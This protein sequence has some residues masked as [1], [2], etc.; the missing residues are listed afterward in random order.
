MKAESLSLLIRRG[1]FVL[2]GISDVEKAYLGSLH[3]DPTTGK[4]R[5]GGEG[6]APRGYVPASGMVHEAGK[7][8]RQI[9]EE[10]H[11]KMAPEASPSPASQGVTPPKTSPVQ[12]TAKMSPPVTSGGSSSPYDVISSAPTTPQ[13][14]QREPSLQPG[15]TFTMESMAHPQVRSSG[16]KPPP[17]PQASKPMAAGGGMSPMAAGGGGK[18]PPLPTDIGMAQTIREPAQLKV[19]AKAIEGQQEVAAPIHG[20]D[21]MYSSSPD[22]HHQAAKH[23]ILQMHH[24]QNGDYD[25]AKVHQAQAK[26][27]V[28]AGANPQLEHFRAAAQVTEGERTAGPRAMQGMREARVAKMRKGNDDE[29]EILT[30]GKGDDR[31]DSDFDPKQLKEGMK[32]EAEHTPCKR[33]R[34]EISK[35]HLTEDKKYYIKLKK[36]EKS[37]LT[38]TDLFKAST[39]MIK[40]PGTSVAPRPFVSTS[41]A[42]Q[43]SSAASHPR[44][45][46]PHHGAI[47]V[48]FSEV[49]PTPQL[50]APKPSQ[51]GAASSSAGH[52]ASS[53]PPP[54]ASSSQPSSSTGTGSSA[55]VEGTASKPR[56]MSA[57]DHAMKYHVDMASK[58]SGDGKYVE[59]NKHQRAANAHEA[60]ISGDGESVPAHALS[61][62]LGMRFTDEGGTPIE[63]PTK[64]EKPGKAPKGPTEAPSRGSAFMEGMGYGGAAGSDVGIPGG[65]MAPVRAAVGLLGSKLDLASWQSARQGT[66][67]RGPMQ[68]GPY[69]NRSIP[70]MLDLHKS[71]GIKLYINL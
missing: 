56:P 3:N 39:A 4:L 49:K 8:P 54:S 51:S 66:Q 11:V 67:L 57:H 14:H 15:H 36:M 19:A 50:S 71:E 64:P 63:K 65:G 37:L 23:M 44:S 27:L 60:A 46:G 22:I 69:V 62:K 28:A 38:M 24:E 70:L 40:H 9:T 20:R 68:R 47:D 5:F 7:D 12:Q 48:E 10:E 41:M 16:A 34:K 53:T 21:P 26:Q 42:P 18:P 6:A 33:C 43:P 13:A 25:R 55:P 58:L 59:A 35:D 30:G 45:S 29:K 2:P 17:I 61:E 52:A 32:V 31:P 1:S